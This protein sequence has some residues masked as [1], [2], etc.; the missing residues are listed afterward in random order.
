MINP[1]S[2]LDGGGINKCKKGSSFTR[3]KPV[4]IRYTDMRAAMREKLGGETKKEGKQR[5]HTIST[6]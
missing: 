6:I 4:Y 2:M 5:H 1:E 3:T